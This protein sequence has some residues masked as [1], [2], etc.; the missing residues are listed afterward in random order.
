M[1]CEARVHSSY[2]EG[3]S[4]AA[5][6]LYKV[7]CGEARVHFSYC[8]GYSHAAVILY[9]VECAVRQGYTPV[10]VRVIHIQQ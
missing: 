3:Y 6:I 9:K 4:H 5:V 10:T 2:C 8:E 7:E 1:W